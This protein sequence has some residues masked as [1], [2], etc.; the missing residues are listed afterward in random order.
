MDHFEEIRAGNTVYTV[1]GG[2]LTVPEQQSREGISIVLLGGG[3]PPFR[4]F[5]FNEICGMEALEVLSLETVPCPSD[6]PSLVQNHI[7]LRFLVFPEETSL[8]ERLN[9]AF[10]EGKSSHY[11]VLTDNVLPEQKHLF[12]NIYS[13]IINPE[14]VCTVPIMIDSNG[15]ILHAAVGP[16]P[17]NEVF[18][19]LLTEPGKKE[20]ATLVPWYYNGIYNRE[21]HFSLGGFDPLIGDP[22]W[23]LL[24]YGMR[25]WLWGEKITIIPGFKVRY[26]D[27]P[28]PVDMT[29]S[30]GYRRY[31]LKTLAVHHKGDSAILPRRHWTA[32]MQHYGDSY[33]AAKADWKEITW[34]VRSNRSRFQLDAVKLAEIWKWDD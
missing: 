15:R 23:Q 29:V 16:M 17:H 26:T 3:C 28:L 30:P 2:G 22:W 34:W 31:Y 24:E 1:I 19:V 12:S 13:S 6:V 27:E 21:K 10:R 33:H 4:Q 5:L 32:Y 25:A 8:G 7:N 20:T 18:D 11:F 14:Q 9:A